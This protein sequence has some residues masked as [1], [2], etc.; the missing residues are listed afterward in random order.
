MVT[1]SIIT[2]ISMYDIFGEIGC[3]INLLFMRLHARLLTVGG[4]GMAIFRIVCI[5][6]LAKQIERKY[7]AK[8]IHLVEFVVIITITITITIVEENYSLWLGKSTTRHQFCKDYGLTKADI[9]Y[10]YNEYD[11]E[12]EEFGE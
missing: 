10:S 11:F 6:N 9:L 4:F 2:Q 8:I 3:A 12:N 5:E 7:L 1:I